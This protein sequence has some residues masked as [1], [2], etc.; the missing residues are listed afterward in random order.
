MHVHKPMSTL[1]DT[2][3]CLSAASAA[4]ASVEAAQIVAPTAVEPLDRV[5]Y[6]RALIPPVLLA[7]AHR[8]TAGSVHVDVEILHFDRAFT[9]AYH[10]L[11]P[12]G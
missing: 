3:L 9:A 12:A 6:N 7:T 4:S 10:L 11:G 2:N 8:D 1:A 5:A